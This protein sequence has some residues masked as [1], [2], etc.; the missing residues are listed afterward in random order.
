MNISATDPEVP[1]ENEDIELNENALND[2]KEEEDVLPSSRA[3]LR[4]RFMEPL[5]TCRQLG[6]KRPSPVQRTIIRSC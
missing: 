5:V 2:A 4:P 1:I 3:A 6:F